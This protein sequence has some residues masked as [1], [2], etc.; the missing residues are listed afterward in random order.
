MKISDLELCVYKKM[1][2][3]QNYQKKLQ[4]KYFPLLEGQTRY[5]IYMMFADSCYSLEE[6]SL[7]EISFVQILIF[8]LD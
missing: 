1:I 2:S 6:S 8:T 7:F 3:G 4:M 5:A